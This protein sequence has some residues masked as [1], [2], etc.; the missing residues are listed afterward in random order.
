MSSFYNSSDH[1]IVSHK[2]RLN[3]SIL[4]FRF[5]LKQKVGDFYFSVK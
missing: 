3:G 1:A 4:L 2:S 5:S